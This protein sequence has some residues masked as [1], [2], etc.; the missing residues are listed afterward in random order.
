MVLI[1]WHL[2]RFFRLPAA[3]NIK[4]RDDSDLVV[5]ALRPTSPHYGL[6]D[7]VLEFQSDDKAL[8]SSDA[9]QKVSWLRHS[10]RP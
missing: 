6:L 2:N 7:V 8:T 9:F 1:G 5:S 10:L 3:M 4:E